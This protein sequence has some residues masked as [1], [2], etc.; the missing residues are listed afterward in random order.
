MHLIR[1]PEKSLSGVCVEIGDD[2]ADDIGIS[3]PVAFP[4]QSTR[5]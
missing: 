1:N 3:A 5:I 4:Q 2:Q